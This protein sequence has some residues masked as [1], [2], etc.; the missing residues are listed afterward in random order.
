MPL[1]D[2]VPSSAADV[3]EFNAKRLDEVATSDSPTYSDRFGNT[4]RTVEGLEQLVRALVADVATDAKIQRETGA[5]VN[6][7][8]GL[9]TLTDMTYELGENQ[10][11][12]F[13]NGVML[14]LAAGEYSE[15]S[16]SSVTIN[17]TLAPDDNVVVMTNQVISANV[18]DATL[19]SKLA[20]VDSEVLIGGVQAKYIARKYANIY[21]FA[22]FGVVG[23]GVTDDSYA[24]QSAL[25]VVEASGGGVIYAR[26]LSILTSYTMLVGDKTSIIFEGS[27]IIY[28][29]VG[30]AVICTKNALTGNQFT[31]IHITGV[32]I[33][34]A[35]GGGA[36]GIAVYR[37][38]RGSVTNCRSD[39]VVFHTVDCAGCTNFLIENNWTKGNE[40]GAYQIDSAVA[41]AINGFLSNGDVFFSVNSTGKSYPENVTLRGNTAID[42]DSSIH[43]HRGELRNITIENNYIFNT[44]DSLFGD[45]SK[46]I[47]T[48]E[49]QIIK[50]VNIIGN[51]FIGTVDTHVDLICDM[52]N[53]NISGN[54]FISS[55]SEG[56]SVRAISATFGAVR[57]N[58]KIESNYFYLY[59]LPVSVRDGLSVSISENEFKDCAKGS[60]FNPLTFSFEDSRDAP[61]YAIN[62]F[63]GTNVRIDKNG[64]YDCPVC[65]IRIG[66]GDDI[67]GLSVYGNKTSGSGNLIKAIPEASQG[68]SNVSIEKNI[69]RFSPY[70]HYPIGLNNLT[71]ACISRNEI[72]TNKNYAVRIEVGV[73]VNLEANIIDCTN[74]TTTND[75]RLI[76][77][78]AVDQYIVR[79]NRVINNASGEDWLSVEVSGD[80]DV[81]FGDAPNSGV[82]DFPS[83]SDLAKMRVFSFRPSNV[84]PTTTRFKVGSVFYASDSP[85]IFGWKFTSSGWKQIPLT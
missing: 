42:C 56:L 75:N 2:P 82:I 66:E 27:K 79:D 17:E 30:R 3:L 13:V 54:K 15:T 39:S 53:I 84:V 64:F 81:Y 11:F 16:I 14:D 69:I 38:D 35:G 29:A 76:R 52:E 36:N 67:D 46:G 59:A 23:D 48:D 41:N 40:N 72:Q 26:N 22:D 6:A 20:D 73:H 7:A 8:S 33:E 24:F 71:K 10:I 78:L 85:S 12:V 4:R 47:I 61:Q 80:G 74:Y 55:D 51:F 31:D 21:D 18:G 34:N 50:N 28:T 37:V 25:D 49:N 19:R 45:R 43:L 63:G 1:N 70:L 44:G 9:I 65:C 62:L 57:K 83:V 77:F 68:V 58:I 60:N 5:D 32:E